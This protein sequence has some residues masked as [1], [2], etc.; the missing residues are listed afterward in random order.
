ML[1]N[2]DNGDKY[3][4]NEKWQRCSH[5]CHYSLC[6]KTLHSTYNKDH[7]AR[8]DCHC[9]LLSEERTILSSGLLEQAPPH[10]SNCIFCTKGSTYFNTPTNTPSYSIREFQEKFNCFTIS[11]EINQKKTLGVGSIRIILVY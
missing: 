4:Q 2:S 10:A 9:N 11:N 1:F 6:M 7:K 3:L 8:T 5:Q